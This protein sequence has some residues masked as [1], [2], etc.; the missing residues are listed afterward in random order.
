MT[1][2]LIGKNLT[3]L[4]LSKI[5]ADKGINVDLYCL[6]NKRANNMKNTLSRTIGL[7]NDSVN[8]LE[9]YK[10]LNKKDC[11]NIKQIKLYNENEL[12]SFLNFK[13]DK[14][15]FSMISYNVLNKSLET[16]LKKNKRLKIKMKR[17]QGFFPNLLKK[18][19]E[20]I[21]I[22]DTN[23]SLFKKYFGR[24]FKKNY[25]STAFTTIINHSKIQNNIA[26]QYFT[27]FGP[28]AFLPISN[29][30][31]SVVFSIFD[32]DLIKDKVKIKNLI[33]KYNRHYKIKNIR[34]LQEF[35]INLFL[36]RNYFYK[37]ILSFG[38]ALHKVHPLAGQGFNMTVRDTKILS[39]LID[40]NLALGL[41]LNTILEKFE[42]ER[43][44]PN[45]IFAMGI[46]FLH[47]FFKATNK[48][49]LKN[50]NYLF[51]FLNKNNYFKNKI[52]KFADKGFIF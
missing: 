49:N 51:K 45:F 37:N 15:S 3:S 6:D 5:F 40:K 41:D 13:P 32:K 47:E 19:Y 25:N 16:K 22:T 31:T 14:N 34:P 17:Y 28:L 46:D 42:I 20:I 1:I 10:I 7:S 24:H 27:K 33:E 9:S 8:F 2:C 52:E 36:S 43:K 11:W 48:Y 35:P 50:V 21:I 38:D 4:V 44:D 30:Q 39:N 18:N 26:E 23:N 29:N 12:N